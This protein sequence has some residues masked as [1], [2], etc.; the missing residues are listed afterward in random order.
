M[1]Q[2]SQ[3]MNERLLPATLTAVG[4]PTDF[5]MLQCV[6][7]P[8]LEDAPTAPGVRAEMRHSGPTAMVSDR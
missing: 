7:S 1:N 3:G 6:V 2:L 4:R 8:L 5:D